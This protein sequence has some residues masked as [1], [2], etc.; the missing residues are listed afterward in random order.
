[1]TTNTELCHLCKSKP[2]LT[3]YPVCEDCYKKAEFQE[4]ATIMLESS[5]KEH[6]GVA[7]LT[8]GSAG[9]NVIPEGSELIG[10]WHRHGDTIWLYVN[11][12]MKALMDRSTLLH[13]NTQARREAQYPLMGPER[14]P[15]KTSRS[16]SSTGRKPRVEKEGQKAE[17]EAPSVS[18]K[19]QSLRDRLFKSS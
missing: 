9:G 15:R 14:A 7:Y 2:C 6:W 1:M 8:D 12:P 13:S 4:K 18:E 3:R 17:A 16:T 19:M 11:E 5:V 10:Y